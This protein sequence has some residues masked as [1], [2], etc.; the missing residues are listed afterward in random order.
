MTDTSNNSSLPDSKVDVKDQN[1]NILATAFTDYL[2][3]YQATTLCG[4]HN[5]AASKEDY[6]TGTKANVE[7]PPQTTVTEDFGLVFG[8]ICEADCTYTGDNIVH[9][10][11]GQINGCAFYDAT[12]A[13]A[14]DLAQ[15]GWIRNYNETH[16]VQCAPGI[17]QEEIK[18]EATVTCEEENLVKSSQIVNFQG[19][20]VSMVVV[21]CG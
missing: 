20:L 5:L 3:N 7:I 19:K 15:P 21:I 10:G 12:A 16:I 1:L 6:V 2:G 18:V 4:T 13:Q 17:P 11:C 8:Q 14:C 9:K